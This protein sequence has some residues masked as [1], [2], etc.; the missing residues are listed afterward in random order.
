MKEHHHA[1]PVAGMLN[2]SSKLEVGARKL[3]SVESERKDL[4][5]D[6]DTCMRGHFASL[7]TC[8]AIL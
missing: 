6:R 3:C 1:F 5:P 8:G 7:Q 2:P 4:N